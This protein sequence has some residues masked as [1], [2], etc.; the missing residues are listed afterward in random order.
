MPKTPIRFSS[1]KCP[2]FLCQNYNL[3]V[4]L[5]VVQWQVLTSRIDD[6]KNFFYNVNLKAL[7]HVRTLYWNGFKGCRLYSRSET[8]WFNSSDLIVR[9]W[10]VPIPCKT[11]LVSAA[12][13]DHR[14]LQAS[15]T[16]NA[17]WSSRQERIWTILRKE[18]PKFTLKLDAIY[19]L[20]V[21]SLNNA[22]QDRSSIWFLVKQTDTIWKNSY[23]ILNRIVLSTA[24]ASFKAEDQLS[25][26]KT[27]SWRDYVANPGQRTVA[28]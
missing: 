6:V 7:L 10:D 22:M 19:G 3:E 25:Q 16:R 8:V 20:H 9:S 14:C 17:S 21:D 23:L 26:M 1:I 18:K 5:L 11:R 4:C 24:C 27:G 12:S 13:G 15:G 2:T 28:S